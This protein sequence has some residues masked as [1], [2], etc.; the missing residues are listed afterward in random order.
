MVSPN[1]A[2]SIAT[3]NTVKNSEAPAFGSWPAMIPND[4]PARTRPVS[5]LW[6]LGESLGLT[7]AATTRTTAIPPTNLK[8][9]AGATSPT[10]PRMPNAARRMRRGHGRTIFSAGGSGRLRMAA[11]MVIREV[12]RA[13]KNTTIRVRIVPAANPA[14]TVDALSE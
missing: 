5:V 12:R 3:T 13:A 2:V 11:V 4:S 6:V 9:A 8:N 10:T 1:T 14:T 7:S